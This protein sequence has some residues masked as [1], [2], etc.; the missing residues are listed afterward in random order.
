MGVPDN[1]FLGQTGDVHAGHGGH[2]CEF[3]D[4]VTG[5]GA[6]D[7]VVGHTGEAELASHRFR[8]KAECIAGQRAG[9]VRRGIDALVPINQ[10]LHVAN[11]RP[12]V[13]HKLVS[14]QHRLGMLHVRTARHHGAT[15]LFALLNQGIN[16]VKQQSGNHTGV[17]A[18]PHANQ[19][20]DLVVA[21][22]AGTQLAAELIA[23]NIDQATFEGS[24][25]ILIVFDRSKGTVIHMALESVERIFH[26][27]QLVGSQESRT[28]ESTGVGAR[29]GDTTPQGQMFV[30]L[31]H[32]GSLKPWIANKSDCLSD[33]QRW[34][35]YRWIQVVRIPCR[36]HQTHCQLSAHYRDALMR[37]YCAKDRTDIY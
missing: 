5:C 23:G 14:K 3:G 22:T 27:L 15:G 6:V 26:A 10:A 34:A 2:E 28:A 9:A 12:S 24:G 16:Q 11:Q 19:A 7:G 17:T 36:E 4:Q 21:G 32:E 1:D 37:H 30:V 31:S 33:Y 18:Q 35:T 25:L 29:T 13:S 20:S 8:V